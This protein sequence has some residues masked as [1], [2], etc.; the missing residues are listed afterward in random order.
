MRII[1]TGLI[2]QYPFGGVTWDYLQYVLGFRA[3]GHDVWYLEDTGAWAYDPLA[4]QPSDDCS[5]NVAYLRRIMEAFDLGD[6]W[7]YR[8]G[9]DGRY[10][11]IDDPDLAEKTISGA[12]VLANVSG[13]C[14]L[15]ETTASIR[16]KL[17]LDG[18]PMFTHIGMA[19]DRSTADRIRSHDVHYSFGL[20]IGQPDCAVPACGLRW[21]PTVQPIVLHYWDGPGID[22]SPLVRDAWATVMNWSSYAAKEFQG[23]SYGQ[24]DVEFMRFL[25]LPRLTGDKFVLAVGQGPGRKRPTEQL[26]GHGWQII[27]PDEAL[28]DHTSYRNFLA[29]AKGEWSI[30]KNGYVKSRSGW[31]SCRSACYLALGKPVVVQD[32]GWSKH[33]PSGQGV[34][35]FTTV[36][37]AVDQIRAV[38]SDYDRHARAARAYACE[39]FEAEKVLS[40]LLESAGV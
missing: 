6:R 40:S 38:A 28:P 30:A 22:P 11:G 18:D 29:G 4:Q 19:T 2:G 13:A 39:Y 31:F 14:W 26:L 37:E 5:N 20:N 32:T 15:R 24:K 33:L 3:L 12:D 34:L 36:D 9:A 8:N 21:I 7:I 35:G 1:C 27:E 16:T 25:D 23:E 10:H 17:F